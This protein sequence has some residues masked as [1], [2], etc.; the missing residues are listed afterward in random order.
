MKN[1]I[2]AICGENTPFEILYP[3]N[4]E[5][6]Q[7]D[8]D[9]F[10]ARRIPDR[11]HYQIVRCRKCGLIFSNPIL[12]ENIIRR[13]YQE[14]ELTYGS[15]I[16]NLKKTYGNYL[17]KI[18]NFVPERNNLLEIGCGNG[19]FLQEALGVGFKNVVGVEP[20]V[21]AV[22][23]AGREIKPFIKTNNFQG[24]L[25][26]NNFFDVICF[27]QTL[28]HIVNPNL[29][30]KD[31]FKI[32]K[33]QGIIFCIVH[34]SSSNLVKILGE[35]TPIFDIEHTYLYNKITLGKIFEK[36]NFEVVKVMNIAN[37][38]SLGYWTKLLPF[39]NQFKKKVEKIIVLLRLEKISLRIK[40][41]N[42]GM[43]A[44]KTK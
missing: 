13:L 30:L 25:F 29:F 28:D 41:G 3:A 17:K 37:E 8:K 27:F 40:A 14:S 44:K 10:S 20:S 4:F 23:K 18:I 19:F 26:K 39:G 32:L 9:L 2:C 5:R 21:E 43:V 16:V 34:D 15:E 12:E 7:I 36:N 42:I 35:K 31:C 11:C 6:G 22:N 33:R 38:Y 1:Q 24:K